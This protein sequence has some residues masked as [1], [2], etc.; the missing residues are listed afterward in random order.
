[1]THQTC[2]ILIGRRL[3]RLGQPIAVLATYERISARLFL[4]VFVAFTES[5]N[6]TKEL[7]SVDKSDPDN[8]GFIT[9]A[10]MT[11]LGCDAAESLVASA[12]DSNSSNDWGAPRLSFELEEGSREHLKRLVLMKKCPKNLIEKLKVSGEQEVRDLGSYLEA[13][14]KIRVR[15]DKDYGKESFHKFTY[16]AQHPD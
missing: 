7:Y 12:F 9:R 6:V 8:S 2:R 14:S 15:L 11:N 5:D 16:L 1:M 4:E 10:D 3:P 13:I